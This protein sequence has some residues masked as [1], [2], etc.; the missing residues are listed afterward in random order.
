ML[1]SDQLPRHSE[2]EAVQAEEETAKSPP[3][4]IHIVGGPPA[5]ASIS[6]S[7]NVHIVRGPPPKRQKLSEEERGQRKFACHVCGNKFKEVCYQI[8]WINNVSHA[9]Q[10]GA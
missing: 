5:G 2:D 10:K 1:F 3:V 8:G 9:T 7:V 4:N 6:S